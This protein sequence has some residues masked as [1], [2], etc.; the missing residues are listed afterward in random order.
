MLN[1][2]R[3]TDIIGQVVENGQFMLPNG[4]VVSP[5]Y[6][7]WTS[8]EYSLAAAP[9]PPAPTEE[10]ILEALRADM[11]LSFAQLLIGLVAEQWITQAEG[12]T[13]LAGSLPAAMEGA[14][15]TL[16]YEAQFPARVRAL[17]PSEVLR[18]DPL[19]N[20]M[21]A[22]QGVSPAQLDAFF[23]SYSQV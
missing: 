2:L 20:G 7:G 12:E 21:A 13:W 22:A 8:G 10:E 5:A 18:L 15:A 16:P 14:I 19:V 9:P 6:A 3:G 17:R 23:V 4:D 11:R 1:I